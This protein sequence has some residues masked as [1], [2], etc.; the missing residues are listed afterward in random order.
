M[1]TPPQEKPPKLTFE[2]DLV[3]KIRL[4]RGVHDILEE[5]SG[6]LL[7]AQ[8]SVN[9]IGSAF[10]T[11]IVFAD[12]G[13]IN[14]LAPTFSGS[15]TLLAVGSL[16]F[17]I[18]IMNTIADLFSLSATNNSHLQAIQQY[19]Y[20]L[21]DIK[22]NKHGSPTRSIDTRDINQ[23]YDRYLQIS[24]NT[25]NASGKKFDKA[26]QKYLKRR[27]IRIATKKIPFAKNE[28]ILN[29]A[30]QQINKSSELEGEH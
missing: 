26:Q 29:L 16:S 27:A 22:K 24:N 23:F 18:F 14:T 21:S 28:D 10:I 11:L 9:L 30:K 13:L 4:Q 7:N 20:L 25:N 5:R 17:F 12:F 2:E 6:L 3:R 15:P 1:S 8:R 19:T